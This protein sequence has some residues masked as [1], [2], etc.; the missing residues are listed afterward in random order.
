MSSVAIFQ[1]HCCGRL[2][3][4]GRY[5]GNR[6]SGSGFY[7]KPF[8]TICKKELPRPN[9]QQATA[10]F[11]NY[12]SEDKLEYPWIGGVSDGG[13]TRRYLSTTELNAFRNSLP[14]SFEFRI[15]PSGVDY[16]FD[17]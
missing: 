13:I 1:M 16:E 15:S 14:K 10:T 7:P 11:I 5:G 17:L 8:C 4:W 12:W 9:A 3:I 2:F 6:G